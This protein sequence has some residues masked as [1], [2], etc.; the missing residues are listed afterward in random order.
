MKETIDSDTSTFY[1]LFRY[2]AV[3]DF[4]EIHVWLASSTNFGAVRRLTRASYV[5]PVDVG[6]GG[7]SVSFL[8]RFNAPRKFDEIFGPIQ[9]LR[10]EFGF[11]S[12]PQIGILELSLDAYAKDS[13]R[14]T[15][16][17]YAE[18][19]RRMVMFHQYPVDD[20]RWRFYKEK[21]VGH[22]IKTEEILQRLEQGYMIGCGLASA[23]HFQRAY[24]KTTDDGGKTILPTE[25]CRARFE[26]S[27]KGDAVPVKTLFDLSEFQFESE[28]RTGFSFRSR[29]EW[30]DSPLLSRVAEEMTLSVGLLGR[31]LSP[32]PNG[33]PV[34]RNSARGTQ[35]VAELNEKA[36]QALR[37][38]T[39]R[40]ASR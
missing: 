22:L 11:G 28:A 13:K 5:E 23:D 2:Q 24:F 6:P 31:R 32:A 1:N 16:K 38:L 37:G 26:N 3:V 7:A 12:E 17:D 8:L 39:A 20:G 9:C 34:Y 27:Y 14:V 25:Q 40:W 19:V 18:M 4:V 33:R 29:V 35:A 10:K 15:P 36:R 21:S 30:P